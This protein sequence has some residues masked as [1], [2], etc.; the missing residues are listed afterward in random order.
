MQGD[1]NDGK[2]G[3]KKNGRPEK[4]HGRVGIELV[5]GGMSNGEKKKPP[6]LGETRL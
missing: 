1:E 4:E 2:R 5:G 3:R 6:S